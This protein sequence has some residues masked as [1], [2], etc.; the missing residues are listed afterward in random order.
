[1]FF[2]S[3]LRSEYKKVYIEDINFC[4]LSKIISIQN[5]THTRHDRAL[6]LNTNNNSIIKVWSE[7]YYN[8]TD[9]VA[10]LEKGYFTNL[11]PIQYLVYDRKNRC[12]G[13]VLPRGKMGYNLT[14]DYSYSQPLFNQPRDFIQLY[15]DVIRANS[16]YGFV[17]YDLSHRT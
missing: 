5:E 13:Y 15:N 4:K 2:P 6:Y 3:V 9:F 14:Y 10:A 8:A 11:S 1:M 7:N 16:D 12:R 17:Y